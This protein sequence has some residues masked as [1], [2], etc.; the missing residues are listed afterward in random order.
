[1]AP[2]RA[3]LEMWVSSLKAA[4]RCGALLV[5]PVPS[6][7]IPSQEA[8]AP[9]VEIVR[10]RAEALEFVRLY[11]VHPTQL[12]TRRRISGASPAAPPVLTSPAPDPDVYEANAQ[13]QFYLLTHNHRASSAPVLA[14]PPPPPSDD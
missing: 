8:A 11:R 7:C 5:R 6:H 2:D 12:H 1:M 14:V 10:T 13:V 3:S 4:M 9:S